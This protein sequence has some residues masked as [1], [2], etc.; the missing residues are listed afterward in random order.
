[1]AM[2]DGPQRLAR[3]RWTADSIDM[4]RYRAGKEI[5]MLTGPGLDLEMRTRIDQQKRNVS[6]SALAVRMEI[7]QGRTSR[8]GAWK[9][10]LIARAVEFQR[11]FGGAPGRCEPT[12]ADEGSPVPLR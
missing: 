1:M 2:N 7:R 12:C 4:R 11:S 3:K 8:W 10:A 5:N 9:S 6:D